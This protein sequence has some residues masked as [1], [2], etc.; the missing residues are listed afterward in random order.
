MNH[1][2]A[3]GFMYG[4][5]VSTSW[6]RA[7]DLRESAYEPA[8][9]SRGVLG[10]ESVS[11]ARQISSVKIEWSEAFHGRI[12]KESDELSKSKGF[13]RGMIESASCV[14]GMHSSER[15]HVIVFCNAQVLANMAETTGVGANKNH[16]VVEGSST[17]KA[18]WFDNDA[19]DLLGS[20]Y[21]EYDGFVYSK[22]LKAFNRWRCQ[23]DGLTN[24]SDLKFYFKRTREDAVQPF[25]AR[26]SDSGFDLT[27]L[28]KSHNIGE[29]EMYH[30]G[31]KAYPAYGWY[32]ILAPR[33]SIIKT[34]YMLANSCGII[35]RSYTGEIL[36]PL[37][38]IQGQ[39]GDLVVPQRIVQLIPTPIID[40]DFIETDES[41]DSNRGE[42]GFGSSGTN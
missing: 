24:D 29:V 21:A 17:R 13:I 35:D 26:I 3:M 37:I 42:G 11:V 40:F 22:I 23:V 32:F 30:T 15:P 5:S 34:G 31:I 25:K 28:E 2:Y 14:T 36:V 38:K 10:A 12:K 4:S 6:G 7:I 18:E 41:L 33:S 16:A 39:K 9:F 8:T 1:E 27:L 20:L 19:L